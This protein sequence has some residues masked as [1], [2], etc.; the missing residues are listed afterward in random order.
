MKQKSSSLAKPR[1]SMK[2]IRANRSSEQAESS[3]TK[4]LEKLE[5]L[6]A[7]LDTLMSA[8]GDLQVMTSKH[9]CRLPKNEREKLELIIGKEPMS[10]TPLSKGFEDSVL[11]SLRCPTCECVFRLVTHPSGLLLETLV[12]PSGEVAR[13]YPNLTMEPPLPLFQPSIPLQFSGPGISAGIQ[14]ETSSVPVAG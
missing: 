10:A 14:S 12:L 4:C 5:S 1:A 8:L 3:S 6:Q 7:Q 2:K 13:F 9:G 11:K